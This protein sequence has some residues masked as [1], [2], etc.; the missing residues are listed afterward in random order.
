MHAQCTK[1]KSANHAD[2]CATRRFLRQS[3]SSAIA[4]RVVIAYFPPQQF[5]LRAQRESQNI[6]YIK[7]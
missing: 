3:I 6:A 7:R 4:R 1:S 2:L 5:Q